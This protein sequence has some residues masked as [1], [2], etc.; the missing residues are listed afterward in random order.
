[1]V[2]GTFIFS[3]YQISSYNRFRK[4]T[5]IFTTIVREKD[6]V[7][8]PFYKMD[9]SWI[10]GNVFVIVVCALIIIGLL[11]WIFLQPSTK[12]RRVHFAKKDDIQEFSDDFVS[13][14]DTF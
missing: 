1:M 7:S 4:K 6:F 11:L 12:K 8:F 14:D 9:V 13:D 5:Y 10:N 2:S 3:L